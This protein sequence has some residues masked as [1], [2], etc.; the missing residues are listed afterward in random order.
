MLHI[1]EL[2]MEGRLLSGL[3][4]MSGPLAKQGSYGLSSVTGNLVLAMPNDASFQLNAKVSGKH[5]IVSD[6]PLKYLSEPPPPRPA[7]PARKSSEAKPKPPMVKDKP[8][9]DKSGPVVESIVIEKPR[10]MVA[11]HVLVRVTAICGSGDANIYIASFGGT[12]RLKR[13]N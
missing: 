6:F 13:F 11:P 10:V 12:V 7:A 8:E 3:L 4:T 2:K 5:V 9:K 1:I